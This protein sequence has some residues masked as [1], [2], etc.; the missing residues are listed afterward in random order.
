MGADIALFPEMCN[1]DKVRDYRRREVRGNA[2]RRPSI[3]HALVSAEKV[4]PFI[5]VELR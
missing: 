1:V 4:E 3:Y 2:Y 5:S